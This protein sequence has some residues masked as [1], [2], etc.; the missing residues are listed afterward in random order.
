[1]GKIVSSFFIS[2][3]GDVAAELRKIKEQTDGDIGMSGSATLVHS[4]TFETGVL[5]LT[6]A[7]EIS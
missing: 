2:L 3:D 4:E 7:P 6:Y 1:M 5:N